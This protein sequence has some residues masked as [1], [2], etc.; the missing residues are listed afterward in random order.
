MTVSPGGKN[1][2]LRMSW[3]RGVGENGHRFAEVV[4]KP[5]SAN[6][7]NMQE[8]QYY[9]ADSAGMMKLI[10]WAGSAAFLLLWRGHHF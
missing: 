10:R 8:S 9:A 7:D 2:G 1:P 6:R 3:Q 4:V 5:G